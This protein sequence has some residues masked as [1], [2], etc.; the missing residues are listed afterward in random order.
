MTQCWGCVVYICVWHLIK[1]K[2][3]KHTGRAGEFFFSFVSYFLLMEALH[4]QAI[5][6]LWKGRRSL[7]FE[8]QGATADIWVALTEPT[9]STFIETLKE[10]QKETILTHVSSIVF[11][12]ALANVNIHKEEEE[13]K[14]HWTC[15]LDVAGRG[16]WKLGEH[17]TKFKQ[18]NVLCAVLF[19][20]HHV[21]PFWWLWL[22]S[23]L[24]KMLLGSAELLPVHS[25]SC[26]HFCLLAGCWVCYQ[27]S[28][29]SRCSKR[30][31]NGPRN[32]GSERDKAT[33]PGILK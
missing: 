32:F 28:I 4:L 21:P 5:W 9:Q 10:F 19:F 23:A 26:F 11:K 16:S 29:K 27:G 15:I 30:I 24:G 12:T 2:V 33:Y 1:S 31:R 13:K 8:S 3:P 22:L 18:P 17:I 14:K 7:I 25:S 20:V 6:L